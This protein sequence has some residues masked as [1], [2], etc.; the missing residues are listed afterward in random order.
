MLNKVLMGM[1]AFAWLIT[2]AISMGQKTPAGK[3]WRMPRV[4]EQ[5]NLSD[6]EKQELDERYVDNR[7]KLIDLKSAVEKERFEL[8]NLME[9]ETLDEAAVM[10]QYDRLEKARAKIAAERFRFLLE[11]RKV[12]GHERFQQ[13]KIRF[14]KFRKERKLRHR[15]SQVRERGYKDDK[16]GRD[17]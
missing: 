1:L 14:K 16:Q 7:R 9:L 11:V 5:L 17:G 12:V 4:A 8:E 10:N 15:G 3:W 2:P 13:L 6:Q